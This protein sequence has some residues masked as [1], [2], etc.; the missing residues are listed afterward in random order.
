MKG[1]MPEEGI[2]PEESPDVLYDLWA[3]FLELNASRRGGLNGPEPISHVDLHAFC[4]L[5]RVRFE[6]WELAAIRRLDAVA[7]EGLAGGED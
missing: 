6:G 1:V 3:Q 7:L 4:S 2:N 5:H